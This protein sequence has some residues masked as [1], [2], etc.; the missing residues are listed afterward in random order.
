MILSK[1]ILVYLTYLYNYFS[2]QTGCIHNVDNR[3][4]IV[5]KKKRW[6]GDKKVLK[7]AL[8]LNEKVNQEEDIWSKKHK[9]H[10][11]RIKRSFGMIAEAWISSKTKK[12]R[13]AGGMCQDKWNWSVF[14]CML[15]WK[16]ISRGFNHVTF[17]VFRKNWRYVH[18]EPRK[19]LKRS[20][21]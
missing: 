12:W 10:Q 6:K 1:E 17:G 16:I 11:K 9:I 5:K 21:Y 3:I 15:F 13:S 20:N 8:H 18:R 14:W 7:N 19:F 4:L 2:F